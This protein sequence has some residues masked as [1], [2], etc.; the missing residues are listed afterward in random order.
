MKAM[1]SVERRCPGQCKWTRE[2]AEVLVGG[3][4]YAQTAPLWTNAIAMS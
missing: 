3:L 4:R 2:A 1:G